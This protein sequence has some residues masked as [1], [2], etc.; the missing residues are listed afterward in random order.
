MPPFPFQ[1]LI[2]WYHRN[3]RHTLPWRQYFNLPIKDLSYHVY[4]SEILLQQTQVDRVIP[5]YGKILARFPTI[6]SLANASYEEFFPYYQWLG[7]YSRAR[8]M[9]RT[10]KIISEEYSRIFPNDT[11]KL[12]ALPGVGPYT[13]AAIRA[14]AYDEPILSF[15][16]NLERIL[17]RYYH[18]SKF[19]KLRKEQK[20]QVQAD[21]ITSGISGREINAAFMD[22]GSLGIYDEYPLAGCKWHQTGGKL[23][24]SEP[25]KK[26][27]FPTKDASIIVTLHK[28]HRIYYSS[29]NTE[30]KPFLLPPT[31][32]DVR[33]S[34]QDFFRTQHHLEASVRPIDKRFF[35][36]DMP[37]VHCNAQVQKGKIP[38]EEYKKEKS[39]NFVKN[40]YTHA[41]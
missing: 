41:Q 37:F 20:A 24:I 3:G 13:A 11:K 21:F 9:L 1:Q 26:T 23:E 38:F 30:Y 35:E 36:D 27:I 19:L 25:R 4:L 32:G 22:L 28:D 7:Y 6:E 15:D 10:A 8:N 2:N 34:V 31:E 33:H 14:F 39:W 12:V 5:F 40:T 18:G 29:N 16:T 17:A